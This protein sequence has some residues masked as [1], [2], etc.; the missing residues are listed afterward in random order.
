MILELKNGSEKAFQELVETY[1]NKVINTC[2]GFVHNYEDA[3]DIAQEVFVEVFRSVNS[4]NEDSTLSTWIYRIATNKALDFLRK[5]RRQ[6]RWSELTRISF[7]NNSEIQDIVPDSKDPN[8]V[9]EEKER[10]AILNMAIDKLADNQKAA[11]TLHKN[12]DL[13]YKEIAA[14]L[15]TSVSSV[16]SLMHRAKKNLQKHLYSYYKNNL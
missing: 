10:R 5:S 1:K 8:T 13:S 11:F 7:S 2:Y 3:N 4:F 16:E 6:K 14:V 12:E 15:K 9:Y